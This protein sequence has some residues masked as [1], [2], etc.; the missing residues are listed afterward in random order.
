[1]DSLIRSNYFVGLCIGSQ[2]LASF[3][4]VNGINTQAIYFCLAVTFAGQLTY[5]FL[6]WGHRI[7]E[8]A[9]FQSVIKKYWMSIIAAPVFFFFAHL[10]FPSLLL[11]ALS[12]L[13]TFFYGMHIFGSRAQS[14]SLRQSAWFKLVSIC[15]VWLIITVGVPFIQS[16]TPYKH[17]LVLYALM[18]FLYLFCL[19]IPFDNVDAPLQSNRGFETLYSTYGQQNTLK[20][21]RA[22]AILCWMIAGFLGFPFL[23]VMSVLIALFLHLVNRDQSSWSPSRYTLYFDG[24]V[25]L[26][27]ILFLVISYLQ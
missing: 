25:L 5:S 18:Q 20:I 11:M 27:A 4:L 21:A 3:A 23:L 8:R 9:I 13:L 15:L 7:L 17:A 19:T 10:T 26:Q 1:M 6:R 24:L 14:F 2:A 22:A 16:A 12:T